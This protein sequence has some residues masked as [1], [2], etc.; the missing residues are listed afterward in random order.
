VNILCRIGLHAR[1]RDDVSIPSFRR[2]GKR[3]TVCAT[4]CRR[5]SYV[6][7]MFEFGFP[8]ELLEPEHAP[9]FLSAVTDGSPE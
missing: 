7:Q 1:Y 5:C 2:P 9:A 6:S 3:D 8:G 4:L